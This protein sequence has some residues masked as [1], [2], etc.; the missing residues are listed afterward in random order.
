MAWGTR[1]RSRGE[2]PARATPPPPGPDAVLQA[3]GRAAGGTV[4]PREQ[5]GVLDGR[6]LALPVRPADGARRRPARH[7][8]AR[9]RHDLTAPG[10]DRRSPRHGRRRLRPSGTGD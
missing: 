3:E 2:G 6:Q 7:A 9:A 10:D 1:W 4:A 8:A 5:P